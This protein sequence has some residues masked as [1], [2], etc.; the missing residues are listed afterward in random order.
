MRRDRALHHL[1]AIRREVEHLTALEPSW[2]DDSLLPDD[3]IGLRAEWANLIDRFAAVA[4]AYMDGQ[5]DADVGA[6]LIDVARLLSAFV[7]TMERM[8]LRQPSADDMKRLGVP[9]AA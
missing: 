1:A 6:Q 9:S 2:L 5:L 8:H 7:P 3:R 4:L